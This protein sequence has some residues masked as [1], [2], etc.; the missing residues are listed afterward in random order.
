M[1]VTT[2]LLSPSPHGIDRYYLEFIALRHASGKVLIG[3]GNRGRVI[4]GTPIARIPV[5]VPATNKRETEMKVMDRRT[6]TQPYN[7][8]TLKMQRNLLIRVP[9]TDVWISVRSGTTVSVADSNTQL[10]GYPP[11]YSYTVSSAFTRP[12]VKC[13][14]FHSETLI[15]Q[16][17][18]DTEQ[19]PSHRSMSPS[20]A[21]LT[22]RNRVQQMRCPSR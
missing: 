19:E 7:D 17:R 3:P 16:L 20:T 12:S 6:T 22:Y 2:E 18:I 4:I 1:L 15:A 14:Y 13:A 11:S 5:Y 21:S 8:N 10:P 9:Q